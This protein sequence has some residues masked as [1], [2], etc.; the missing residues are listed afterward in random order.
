MALGVAKCPLEANPASHPTENHPPQLTGYVIYSLSHT[1]SLWAPEEQDLCV[2]FSL[3]DSPKH[4]TMPSASQTSICW[5]NE[6]V[7][8]R[9]FWALRR[10]ETKVPAV[11]KE[12]EGYIWATFT[13]WTDRW[14][15]GIFNLHECLPVLRAFMFCI[16]WFP[17]KL[18]AFS[19]ILIF[20]LSEWRPWDVQW[21]VHRVTAASFGLSPKLE[22]SVIYHLSGIS[23]S[24]LSQQLEISWYTL[25]LE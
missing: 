8:S 14:G 25:I 17:C 7:L 23:F 12:R 9:D 16:T 6:W 21:C 3:L 13:D 15:G 2:F 1:Q 22:F 10:V 5:I 11:E 24:E 19:T 18:Q 4:T 20:K